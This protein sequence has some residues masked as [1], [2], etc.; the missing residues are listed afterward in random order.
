MAL[1]STGSRLNL[2][3]RQPDT[4]TPS[5][6]IRA[7]EVTIQVPPP[8]ETD[9]QS[10]AP[11]RTLPPLFVG[12]SREGL[13]IAR[14]VESQLQRDAE[15]TLWTDGVFGLS[16]GSLESLVEA[17]PR[18]HF[19]VLVLT[20]DDIVVSRDVS[21]LS[22]RDNVLL[23]LGLFL[24]HLGRSRTF[25]V[26]RTDV[27]GLPSDLAGVTIAAYRPRSDGNLIAAMGPACTEIRAAIQ[28]VSPLRPRPVRRPLPAAIAGQP[29]TARFHFRYRPFSPL[30]EQPAP[31]C[32]LFNRDHPFLLGVAEK[33]SNGQLVQFGG[34]AMSAVYLHIGLSTLVVL[35]TAG[36][37]DVASLAGA[38]PEE[39]EH[40]WERL[41]NSP[42]IVDITPSLAVEV[43]Q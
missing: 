2:S 20:P 9:M 33:L 24:G 17:L 16:H 12:S 14:A 31:S 22:A 3:V 6:R 13:D 35:R 11:P 42:E 21:H 32:F 5:I 30:G 18:F 37:L 23:E 27:I 41:L 15:I 34:H 40:F 19:A 4:T 36:A 43:A 39:R 1:T 8:L 7:K 26:S 28:S 25:V 29:D 38:T 10:A